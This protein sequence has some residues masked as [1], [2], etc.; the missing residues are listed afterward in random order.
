MQALADLTGTDFAAAS[1]PEGRAW[2]AALPSLL[3]ELARQW[4]LTATGDLFWHG[5]NAVV[6]PVRQGSRPLALKLAWPPGQAGGEVAALTA[7]RARGMVEL[8]AADVPRGALLLERLDASRSLAGVPPAQAAAIAGTLARTLAIEA[9]GSFPSLQAEARQ[10]TTTLLARQ[11]LLHDPVPGQ[12]ITL[13]VRLAANL[14]ED[15]ARLLV[16]TDL[17]YDNILASQ[18]PGQPWV[19]IDPAAAVGA[20]ERSVAELLWTR[21]DEL[22]GPQAITGLLGILTESGQMDRARA[23]AWGF[24][25][26][27][28]YWLWGLENGL[29]IDPARC[30]R[31]ASA[32]AP[33]AEHSN[34]S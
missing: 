11:R 22:P 7:W 34:Q 9:P 10:L 8:A 33:L 13:A 1:S 5:Y 30:R 4:N 19:A 16:H 26:S 20:P 14:A 27:I 28:D 32:L 29:T 3:R 12:W 18:R 2:M 17:H 25:R 24:V 15:P 23:T 31:V 6:F 21:A